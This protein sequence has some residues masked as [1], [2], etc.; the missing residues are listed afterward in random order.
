MNEI[1]HFLSQRILDNRVENILSFVG[2]ILLGLLFKR[3]ISTYLSKLFYVG[4]RNASEDV[5]GTTNTLPAQRF[6]GLLKKPVEL[7][8]T[9]LVLYTAFSFLQFPRVWNFP[10]SSEFGFRMFLLR[11][12]QIA[13]VSSVTWILLRLIDFFGYVYANK[14]ALSESKLNSQLVPFFKEM[15]KILTVIC[16]IFFVLGAVFK[17]DIS[18]LIAGLGIG[19]LA[20]AL[21]GKETLENLFAS[22][23]IFLDKPFVVG[24]TVQVGNTIGTVEKVG[25][26]STRIRT[27]EKSF[28]TLPN[29]QMVD[30]A[31]D[32][33]TL[34]TFRRA[35]YTIS[36]AYHTPV[37]KIKLV[38]EEIKQFID[39]HP[40]TNEDGQVR[41]IGFGASSLDVMV[42]YFVDTMEFA[43]FNRIREEVNFKIIEIVNKHNCSFAFPSTSVYFENPLKTT[44]QLDRIAAEE[45]E[46]V[47]N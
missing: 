47:R 40:R 34:R 6:L 11:S 2:V 28:L 19:G 7:L 18:S 16:S 9:L 20:V 30:Q 39:T 22:F 14:V 37:E 27:L 35:S 17:L 3:I 5:E 46:G 42:Q 10:P 36:L 24:D 41:F 8:I 31:L 4:I 29:K 45:T 26:R 1:Q 12:Y 25:F 44:P 21:A 23:T 33:L 32:N 13:I 15:A 43:E 38:T